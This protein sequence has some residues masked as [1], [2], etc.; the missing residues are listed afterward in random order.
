[1]ASKVMETTANKTKRVK[2]CTILLYC[3]RDAG[4]VEQMTAILRYVGTQTECIEENFV[5]FIAVEEKTAV[6]LTDTTLR[7]LQ[8]LRLD[9][10]DCHVHCYGSG[11]NI[12]GV[13]SGVKTKI[14]AI[15]QR[16]FFTACGCHY[17]HLLLGDAAKSSRMAPA[18]WF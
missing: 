3:T 18:F 14:L 11:A 6:S 10:N 12:V 16:T 5:G 9:V 13:N 15:H 17:C 1:M 4:R 2:Y 8:C 7:E